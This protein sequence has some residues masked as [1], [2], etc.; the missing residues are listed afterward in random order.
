MF[1]G[2]RFHPFLAAAKNIIRRA[3]AADIILQFAYS[4]LHLFEGQPGRGEMHN[5][6]IDLHIGRILVHRLLRAVP[7]M[8][9]LKGFRFVFKNRGQELDYLRIGDRIA[10]GL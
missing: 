3:V 5:I 8:E 9:T 6:G 2:I 7:E 1:T 10:Y 4:W